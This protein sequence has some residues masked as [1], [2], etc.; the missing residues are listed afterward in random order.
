MTA[1][2]WSAPS[3]LLFIWANC[4]LILLLS[5]GVVVG[6]CTQGSICSGHSAAKLVSLLTG[7]AGGSVQCGGVPEG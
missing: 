7:A 3:C 6:F 5:F 1:G 2:D 4:V